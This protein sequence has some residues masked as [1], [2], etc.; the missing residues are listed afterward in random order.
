MNLTH[1]LQNGH[2]LQHLGHPWCEN[3]VRYDNFETFTSECATVSHIGLPYWVR[4][5]G[6]HSLCFV[7][8]RNLTHSLKSW[9]QLHTWDTKAI[10]AHGRYVNFETLI[11]ECANVSHIWLPY[12]ARSRVYLSL[13]LAFYNEFD[14]FAEKVTTV[15]HFE[16][17]AVRIIVFLQWI[18]DAH[19]RICEC[20]THLASR[21]GAQ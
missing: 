9:R 19:L 10:E 17:T 4:S 7:F 13:C 5:G 21:A 3:A 11:S 1:S 18:W 16:H 14:T 15:I 2:T 20:I 8:T 6:G 12:G